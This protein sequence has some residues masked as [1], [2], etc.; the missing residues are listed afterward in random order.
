MSKLARSDK[1][2]PASLFLPIAG[3]RDQGEESRVSRDSP[4]GK[5]KV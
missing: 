2:L 1:S 5:G 3:K 4:F